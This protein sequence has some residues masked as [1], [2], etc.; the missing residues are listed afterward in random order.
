[1]RHSKTIHKLKLLSEKTRTAI[2]LRWQQQGRLSHGNKVS[3]VDAHI[4]VAT[5]PLT[6][7]VTCHM[8]RPFKRPHRWICHKRRRECHFSV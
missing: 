7:E 5:S 8:D 6:L 2:S 1:L 4:C 3:S